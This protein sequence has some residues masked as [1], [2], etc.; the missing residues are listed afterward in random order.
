MGPV[1]QRR[2]LRNCTICGA[3][4]PGR[5]CY[6]MQAVVLLT[7]RCRYIDDEILSALHHLRRSVARRCC[8]DGLADVAA[9]SRQPIQVVL[10]GKVAL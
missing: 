8:S 7:I 5:N 6:S 9:T 1:A 4:L 10:L 3:F 2:Q